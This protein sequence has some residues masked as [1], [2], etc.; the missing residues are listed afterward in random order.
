MENIQIISLIIM[1]NIIVLFSIPLLIWGTRKFHRNL[2][3]RD[4]GL[5]I[6]IL[7]TFSLQAT[8]LICLDFFILN[9]SIRVIFKQMHDGLAIKF[10]DIPYDICIAIIEYLL[11][12]TIIVL[13]N[14]KVI[15]ISQ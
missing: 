12:W 2:A 1:A 11:L 8:M 3:R 9:F 10:N 4:I 14:K 13:Q 15:T 6:L 5:T 7:I